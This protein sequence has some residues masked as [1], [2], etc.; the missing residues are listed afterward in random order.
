[1]DGEQSFI[2]EINVRPTLKKK[3]K[4]TEDNPSVILERT[5]KIPKQGRGS[6]FLFP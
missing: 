3:K 5:L 4:K 6:I 1:M 2:N